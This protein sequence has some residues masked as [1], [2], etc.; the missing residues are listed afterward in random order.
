M[1]SELL[2]WHDCYIT[3]YVELVFGTKFNLLV[4]DL[5]YQIVKRK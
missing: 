5:E 1:L 2:T 4:F 3:Y